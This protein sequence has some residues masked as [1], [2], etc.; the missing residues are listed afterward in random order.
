M[1]NE[2]PICRCASSQKEFK[3]DARHRRDQCM[4]CKAKPEYEV[5]WAEGMAHAWFCEKHLKEWLKESVA[6]CAKEGFSNKNCGVDSV[7]KLDNKEASKKFGDS[8]NAN[9][10][11]SFLSQITM[12]EVNKEKKKELE[13]ELKTVGSPPIGLQDGEDLAPVRPS[14]TDE[15]EEIT[16]KQVL[17]FFKSFYNAKPY[18]SLVG[19]LANHGKTKNDIDIFIR[20]KTEDIATEFRIFR[21]FPVEYRNRILN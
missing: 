11:D 21:M 9:I 4:S 7:K 17:P 10:L 6:S 19:G 1:S 12:P 14:G 20:S 16:L 8:R 3:Y 2:V 18:V 15:Q 13:E 5:L